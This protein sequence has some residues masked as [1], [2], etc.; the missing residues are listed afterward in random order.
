MNNL[1]EVSLKHPVQRLKNGALVFSTLL[2]AVAVPMWIGIL[3]GMP[4]KLAGY[5]AIFLNLNNV[6]SIVACPVIAWFSAL[7][8]KRIWTAYSIVMLCIAVLATAFNLF[9]WI[10]W[11]TIEVSW[12]FLRRAN[13]FAAFGVGFAAAVAHYTLLTKLMTGRWMP[14]LRTFST[15]AASFLVFFYSSQMI[16]LESAISEEQKVVDERHRIGS[17]PL[18]GKPAPAFELTSLDGSR[19]KL[20]DLRGNVVILDFWATWCLPC[21]FTIP[22]IDRIHR[23]YKVRDVRVLSL[24]TWDKLENA[25]KFLDQN[26]Y[27]FPVLISTEEVEAKYLIHAIPR[28]IIIDK[29]GIVRYTAQGFANDSDHARDEKICVNWIN[30]LLAEQ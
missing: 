28:F 21:Q 12:E 13:I 4:A 16:I 30:D 10:R 11:D 1:P 27:S 23:D 8:K 24:L 18:Q 14:F 3:M 22:L 5:S 17:I 6:I 25:K 29:K 15:I 26:G 19:T 7:L 20:E 9:R 2:L